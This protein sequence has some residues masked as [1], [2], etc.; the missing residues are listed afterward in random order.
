M[1]TLYFNL[2]RYSIWNEILLHLSPH[3]P[4]LTWI[5]AFATSKGVKTFFS[6]LHHIKDLPWFMQ[7]QVLMF[8]N[9]FCSSFCFNSTGL[10]LIAKTYL[11][12]IS[13]LGS[14]V[15]TFTLT[16]YLIL[17]LGCSFLCL[18]KKWIELGKL[19]SSLN[20]KRI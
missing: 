12:F 15:S 20:W 11:F 3:S 9:S 13:L 5:I 19:S 18:S 10:S 1:F 2:R 4:L 14:T 8:D 6:K 17:A 7:H 16:K